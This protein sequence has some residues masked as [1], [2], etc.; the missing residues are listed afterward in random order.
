[1]HNYIEEVESYMTQPNYCS[2]PFTTS[3]EDLAS[4]VTIVNMHP[5]VGWCGAFPNSFGWIRTVPLHMP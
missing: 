5:L 4:G 2:L 1:M 3:L